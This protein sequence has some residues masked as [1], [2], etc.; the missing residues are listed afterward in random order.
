M[1]HK[2]SIKGYIT[3]SPFKLMYLA[4]EE[5]INDLADSY[6]VL[7]LLPIVEGFKDK[8]LE[9]ASC[10]YTKVKSNEQNR[11]VYRGWDEED[12]IYNKRLEEREE[13]VKQA[14]DLISSCSVELSPIV[15]KSTALLVPLP[16][17]KNRDIRYLVNKKSTRHKEILKLERNLEEALS[18]KNW[19]GWYASQEDFNRRALIKENSIIWLTKSKLVINSE[20][21]RHPCVMCPNAMEA[22]NGSCAFGGSTCSENLSK[23]FKENNEEC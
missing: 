12:F 10:P 17:T 13:N 23:L 7:L 16:L 11:Y 21:K 5:G 1:I 22:L 19:G 3:G 4:D 14:Q 2:I 20:I 6:T 15:D 18:N 8:I 9:W